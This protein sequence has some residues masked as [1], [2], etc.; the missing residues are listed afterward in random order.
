MIQFFPSEILGQGGAATVYRAIDLDT[1]NSVALK[2]FHSGWQT[3][4]RARREAAMLRAFSHPNV[5]KYLG[6]ARVQGQPAIVL[7]LMRQGALSKFLD[8]PLEPGVALELCRQIVEALAL[9]HDRAGLHRDVNPANILVDSEGN[10]K[11]GDFEL[12]NAPQCTVM[13]TC[14]AGGTPGYI[15]PE[16]ALGFDCSEASDIYSLAV[17][18]F[19]ML[20]AVR[21]IT[22]CEN[23]LSPG[24]L[25]LRDYRLDIPEGLAELIALST[26]T[27]LSERPSAHQFL[28]SVREILVLLSEAESWRH[29][30]SVL[31]VLRAK[32]RPLGKGWEGFHGNGYVLRGEFF[33]FVTLSPW[34]PDHEIQAYHIVHDNAGRPVPQAIGV[35]FGPSGA[36]PASRTIRVFVGLPPRDGEMFSL[37]ESDQSGYNYQVFLGCG[38]TLRDNGGDAIILVDARNNETVDLG[39]YRE[40]PQVGDLLIR[41]ILRPCLPVVSGLPVGLPIT[42]LLPAR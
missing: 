13:F 30:Q 8:Q 40:V 23:G 34:H 35:P 7:E 9:I 37:D 16:V 25:N 26:S 21:P 12:G 6:M 3:D 27:N 2:V 22:L 19:Q 32:A 14:N 24:T 10:L 5:V 36:I 20:T 31:R 41:T 17:T 4:E 29:R 11:L 28:K 42:H 1:G 39:I 33:D 18:L 15:A 38:H